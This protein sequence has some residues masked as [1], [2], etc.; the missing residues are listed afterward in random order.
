MYRITDTESLEIA[1]FYLVD[2]ETLFDKLEEVIYIQ[3]ELSPRGYYPH[4]EW[5]RNGEFK[6]DYHG[7]MYIVRRMGDY[8]IEVV[9]A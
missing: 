5:V 6:A 9:R 1:E 2:G 4:R 7:E 8:E 3:W